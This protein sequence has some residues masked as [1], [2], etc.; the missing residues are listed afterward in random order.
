MKIQRY[1]KI[2]MTLKL[3]QHVNTVIVSIH[4]H[5]YL[6]TIDWQICTQFIYCPLSLVPGHRWV[7]RFSTGWLISCC[8]S[9]NAEVF[10]C[11]CVFKLHV[12]MCKLSLSSF[13][14]LLIHLWF[15]EMG[16][17]FR[18]MIL[19]IT[20]WFMAPTEHII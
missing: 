2:A 14:H 6:S 17:K 5:I 8:K 19:A 18:S 10:E 4:L 13:H 12:C 16:K 1:L 20:M 9:L 7:D 15:I 11:H 3:W